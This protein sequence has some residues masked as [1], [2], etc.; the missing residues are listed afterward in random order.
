MQRYDAYFKLGG[1]T[2]KEYEPPENFD[3]II[4]GAGPGGYVAA[5]YAAKH[6]LKVMLV[7]KG[8]LGGTC[9]NRGC[10]PTKALLNSSGYIPLLKQAAL[11]GVE[12]DKVTVNYA[13]MLENKNITV[14]KLAQG[15]RNLLRF[16][17]VE[18]VQGAARMLNK[19]TIEINASDKITKAMAKN[20]IIA[21]GSKSQKLKIEGSE[22]E[23]V[24][25]TD[26]FLNM[27]IVPQSAIIIGGGVVGIEYAFILNNLGTQVTIVEFQDKVLASLD[28][29][30]VNVLVEEMSSKGINIFTGTMVEKI[31]VNKTQVAVSISTPKDKTVLNADKVVIAVGRIPNTD[32]L[33][34]EQIGV[35]INKGRV[36]VND[37]MQTS[38]D[39]IFAIGDV[40]GAYMLAHVASMEG[41]VAVDNIIGKDK[42]MS[43]AAIPS[44]LY[45]TPEMATVGMSEEEAVSAGYKIKVCK[46]PIAALGKAC[47]TGDTRGIF[48]VI[49]E[50]THKEILGVHIIGSRATDLIAE[51]TLAI[52]NEMTIEE[53]IE[54]VHAHPTLS[55]GLSETAQALLGKAIHIP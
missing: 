33:N 27:K 3:L 30:I 44:C 45:S 51:A 42:Q 16:N 22:L 20:I 29:D 14:K 6:G 1:I 52:R 10:I 9:L 34:L 41:I 5:I 24:L 48:K 40:T 37:K 23:A 55:E 7:E 47:A 32:G 8:E 18:V 31:S 43:Y 39:N 53:I 36:V 54:T 2:L 21:T 19:T 49:I 4:I 50:E 11:S 38:I 35:K 12:V 17:G 13:R 26:D 28:K 25:N 46:L 15:V